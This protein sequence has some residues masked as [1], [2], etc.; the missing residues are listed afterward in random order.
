MSVDDR[1]KHLESNK[2]IHIVHDE[3]AAEGQCQVDP[4]KV[5][6]HF[7][8]IVAVGGQLYELDGR[9]NFPVNHGPTTEDSFIKDAAQICRQFTEREKTEVRFSAVALC[10]T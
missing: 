10:R 4:D 2:E 3:V 8:S 5:N 7:I 9:L 1:A 6:F